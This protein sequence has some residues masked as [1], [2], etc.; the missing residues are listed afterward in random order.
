MY[1][2]PSLRPPAHG[3][4]TWHGCVTTG[5]CNFERVHD[6]WCISV[7]ECVRPLVHGGSTVL[8]SAHVRMHR[9]PSEG[10]GYVPLG[11]LRTCLVMD[12]LIRGVPMFRCAWLV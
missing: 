5:L 10:R 6:S 2:A 7:H 1:A 4:D 3:P 11:Y 9:A 12:A 8:P